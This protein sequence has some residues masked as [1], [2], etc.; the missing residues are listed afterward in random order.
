MGLLLPGLVCGQGSSW[1][2]GRVSDA[3]GAPLLGA[4]VR[5]LAGGAGAAVTDSAG[6]FSLRLAAGRYRLVVSYVGFVPDTLGV[7]MPYAGALRVVLLG[8]SRALDAVT[9]STGYQDIPAE[10]ATGSFVRVD[11]GLLERTVSTDL[12][13]RLQDVVP[14]LGFNPV[15]TQVSIR[16]QSTLFSNAEPLVVVDGFPFNAPLSSLNPADVASVSVLKDAAAASIW[17]SRAGNGVIVVTTKRGSFNQPLQVSLNSSVQWIGRPDLFYQRRMSSGD[18]I[19]LER[20]LFA[21]GYDD[22]LPGA[23]GHPPLSPAAEVL[24][25]QRDGLLPAAQAD[26]ALAVLAGQDVRRDISRYLYRTGLNRQY[27]LGLSGGSLNQ[28]YVFSAG[29]DD[30]RDNLVGNGFQRVTVSGGNTWALAGRRLEL[31]ASGY[32]SENRTVRNNPGALT[33][34]RGEPVYPYA[35][36]R[37]AS[38]ANLALVHDY[39][40]GFLSDARS[41]GLLDWQYRPLDEPGLSD[42]RSRLTDVRV[43]AS[44]KYR[45][46]AGLS[47]SLA[48]RYDRGLTLGRDLHGAGSYYTRNLVNRYTQDDGAGNL[49][50]PLP[51]GGILDLDDA[52]SVGHDLRAQLDLDRRLGAEGEL[53]A[54]AGYELQSLHVLEDGSRLY[55][56]DSGHATAVPV[57]EANIYSFY[58][59]PGNGSAIPFGGSEADATDHYL[60]WYG[61]AAYTYRGRYTLS[62]SARLDRSNL[63][64]V[65]SNRKGVPLWSAGLSWELSKEDFYG[66]GG[67]PY[68]RLRVT[69]GYNGNVNKSLSAYTTAAYFDGSGSQTH[70]PYATVVNPPD[71]E[72]RWERIGQLNLGLDF[73]T[74]GEVLSGSIDYFRKRGLD[75]IGSTAFPPSSG[76][77]VFT[78]NASETS[79]RGLDLS[80]ELRLHWGGLSWRSSG[81]LSYI[82]DRVSRYDQRQDALSYLQFGALGYYPLQGRPLYAVYSLR[83]AGLDAQS[84]DPQGVLKGQVSRDYA[85]L[86]GVSPG[87]LVYNGPSRPPVFGAWRNS[88]SFRGF[89]VSA[90]L[91][92]ELGFYFR[93][94]S[95]RYGNDYGLSGQSGDFALRW[96]R[97]GD[98]GHTSVPSLP[99]VPDSQR[100]DF[101]T[102]ASVLVDK[103]DNVRLRDVQLSYTLPKGWLRG[104]PRQSLQVY[105]YAANLGLVWRANRDHQ[106]PDFPNTTPAPR[107]LALGVHLIF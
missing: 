23:D 75:L 85:A 16:G 66:L 99:V 6:G 48:Y 7:V 65:A 63:F 36:L 70:L 28:R 91:A 89:S 104:L 27:Q 76:I 49:S 31:S 18:Y 57:D 4:S 59:N 17:G 56:Y 68:L 3:G 61:N 32:L 97:P 26:A 107:T 105:A 55:G 41:A 43:N 37:D 72:L 94:T 52:V 1:L 22:A 38:G 35:V 10:R 86:L 90:T 71:P 83:W 79:G 40:L 93:R 80:L 15:G 54:I 81:W 50:R 98:E 92:Y 106:D 58:D 60:S 101:Y 12:L 102:Y 11:R 13:P 8:V 29:L 51:A 33:W 84:G 87:E 82:S 45:V 88:W 34:N 77:T 67:L 69:Y 46:L 39:R 47:A 42:N 73:H 24:V 9:V 5:V 53:S 19:A 14:G 95:V 62:A 96:Q 100:D 64:G 2:S 30:N 21:E 20:R 78:G 74:R 103:G 44:G 25:S